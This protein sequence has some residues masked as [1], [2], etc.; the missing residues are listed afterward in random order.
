MD[1]EP[2]FQSPSGPAAQS[3]AHPSMASS[4][5]QPSGFVA[6]EQFTTMSDRWAE[7]FARME[8]L[9]SRGNISSTPVS[10]VKPVDSQQLV[11]ETPFLAPATRP[12]GPV[13]VLVAVDA[14]VKVFSDGQKSAKLNLL[15]NLLNS[16]TKSVTQKLTGSVTGLSHRY[17]KK[18]S[19]TKQTQPDHPPA[20]PSSGPESA[21]QHS[22]TAWGSDQPPTDLEKVQTGPS[23]QSSS[24]S[25]QPAV[26]Q[27]STGACAFPPDTQD[28]LFEQ[29]S[30]VD[31]DRSGS[32]SGSEPPEQ[33]EDM[34][35]RET[36]RSVRSFMGWHHIPTF[37]SDFSEPDKSNNPWK[38]KQPRKPTRISVAMPPDDWLCKKLEQLNLT[39]AEG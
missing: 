17:L 16:L 36:V 12:T 37:E 4:T 18:T 31:F 25:H 2:T 29:I 14:Q 5:A 39:V 38:G 7:Q 32:C 28:T 11:S 10:A 27:F 3:P 26:G 19:E 9:L 8:A 30:E 23:S 1:M 24:T 6:A 22:S 13:K 15:N 34:T 21:N 35:Y 20:D 33:T